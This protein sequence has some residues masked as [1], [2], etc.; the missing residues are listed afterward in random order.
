[1]HANRLKNYDDAHDRNNAP[2][3]DSQNDVNHDLFKLPGHSEQID[4]TQDGQQGLPVAVTN[5]TQVTSDMTLKQAVSTDKEAN[6]QDQLKLIARQKRCI[7]AQANA[8]AR[9][10]YLC[11][12]SIKTTLFNSYYG[13]MNTSSLWCH[14]KKQSLKGITV[15]YNNSFRIIHNLSPRCSASHMFATNYVKSFNERIHSSIFS[16]LC[17][18]KKSDGILFVNYLH[19]FIYYRSSLIK[20]W[21]DQLYAFNS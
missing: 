3:E 10:F 15:A 5:D 17:R 13:S 20:H 8:L 6:D 1:M 4:M 19:T 21:I 14:F 2:V 7:Y 12:C 16:L 18:L 9:K 11:N